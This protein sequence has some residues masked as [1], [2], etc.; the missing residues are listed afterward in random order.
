MKG[1]MKDREYQF[2]SF[3]NQRKPRPVNILK[4]AYMILK[5]NS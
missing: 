5:Y 2:K 1:K 4:T 3:K